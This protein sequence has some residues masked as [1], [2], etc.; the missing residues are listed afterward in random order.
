MKNQ[1][2]LCYNNHPVTSSKDLE[3]HNVSDKEFKT[4]LKKFNELKKTL[5]DNSMKSGKQYINKMKK[6]S[7]T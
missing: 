1:R 4:V 7:K 3:I 2:N 5:K 6:L